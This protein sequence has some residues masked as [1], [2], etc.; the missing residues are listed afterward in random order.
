MV[1]PHGRNVVK[2]S[3]FRD[4]LQLMQLSP[5][6]SQGYRTQLQKLKIK[7]THYRQPNQAL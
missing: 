5:R 7:L 6:I 4:F 3:K 2:A 1:R